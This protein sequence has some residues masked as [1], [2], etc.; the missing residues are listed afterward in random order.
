MTV[1]ILFAG[2]PDR[3]PEYQPVFEHVFRDTGLKVRI[4][5]DLSPEEV[6]FIVYAP[7][8]PVQDFSPYTRCRAVLS[9]WAGVE[10]IVQN[11]TLTMPLTRMVDH[12][13]S[14][15]MREWVIGHVL[16]HHLGMDRDILNTE[17]RWD[18]VV[19]PLA[20]ERGVTVL[21]LGALGETCA[22]TLAG[23]GFD[24]TGW[25]R[26]PKRIDGVRCLSGAE[27]LEEALSRA[28]ILVLLLPATPETDNILNA[29][30]LDLLPEGAV[31]INPGRGTL[32]DD[33]ALLEALG[34]GRVGHATLDVFRVEPLPADHPYWA[35]PR[36][37]VTPHI[38]AETR[39]R[40]SAEVIA[41]NV[42]R[43]LAG[44][45][46]LYLVDREAGY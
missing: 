20:Q 12:G 1:N 4:A 44:E 9:L 14:Q 13:L 25:S 18:P 29:R 28:E 26:T 22:T 33:D 19:P 45:P 23:L 37:T 21:G 39:A 43:S 6:D 30:T 3:W 35:H 2:R 16:R 24:V 11:P 27:G 46:L 17:A 40:T 42:R 34:S 41:E 8:G 38:A 31:I 15:G 7:N 10:K 32:I 5:T 36:V